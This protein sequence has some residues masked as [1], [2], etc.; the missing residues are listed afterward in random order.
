MM[1]LKEVFQYKKY[2]SKAKMEGLVFLMEA[3]DYDETKRD[4]SM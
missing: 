3:I 2:T 1:N 4:F